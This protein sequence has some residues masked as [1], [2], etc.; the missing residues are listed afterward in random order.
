LS[1]SVVVVQCRLTMMIRS[2]E[3]MSGAFFDNLEIN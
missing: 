2:P 3:Y 1:V